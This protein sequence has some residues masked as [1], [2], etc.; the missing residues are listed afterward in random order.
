M[1]NNSSLDIKSRCATIWVL[2]GSYLLG[3]RLFN[4][5][6]VPCTYVYGHVCKPLTIN[7]INC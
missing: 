6:K 1:G 3:D 7:P 2:E 5:N 4:P